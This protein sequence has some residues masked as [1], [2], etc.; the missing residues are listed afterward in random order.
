[1][2]Q[3]DC[4]LHVGMPKCGSSALQSAFSDNPIL[5]ASDGRKVK[6]VA[7]RGDAEVLSGE[8]LRHLAMLSAVGY[9]PSVQVKVLSAFSQRKINKVKKQLRELASDGSL[10][11]M[12]NEAWGNQ[13]SQ[14]TECNFLQKLELN[15]DVVMY[16]RPQ[17]EW[18]NSAWWQWG[19]WS[20]RTLNR[21]V[22]AHEHKVRWFDT[23]QGWLSVAS[24]DKVSVRLLPK[25]ILSDFYTLIN[26]SHQKY[27]KQIKAFLLHYLG[28]FKKTVPFE[29]PPTAL[30]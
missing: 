30:L 6:Y 7:I 8:K 25:D 19:A 12:S 26:V 20:D 13:Y 9:I 27:L 21:W 1:M 14:F 22:S 17:V 3:L 24:V 18:F 10:L 5:E 15:I 29:K 2:K 11:I 4:V 28:C 23:Y 16:V